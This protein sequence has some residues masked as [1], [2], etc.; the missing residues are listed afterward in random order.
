MT[1]RRMTTALAAVLACSGAAGV[2]TAGAAENGVGPAPDTGNARACQVH[3]DNAGHSNANGLTCATLTITLTNTSV[4]YGDFP[5]CYYAFAGSGLEPGSTVLRTV[6]GTPSPYG[7]VAS[8]GTYQA[9]ETTYAGPAGAVESLSGTTADGQ[10]ITSN[11]V[12]CG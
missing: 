11:Q 10:T 8:D 7:S 5:V 12:T 9:T 6:N 2:A 4:D 3:A 1:I